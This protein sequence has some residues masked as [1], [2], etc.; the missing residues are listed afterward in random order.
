MAAEGGEEKR[1]GGKVYET[2]WEEK[3]L[4]PRFQAQFYLPDPSPPPPPQPGGL[5]SPVPKT[6]GG[7]SDLESKGKG[8]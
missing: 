5:F 3:A 2:D 8:V 1:G 7:T 4:L 6:S